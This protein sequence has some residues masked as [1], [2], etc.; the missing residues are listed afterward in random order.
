MAVAIAVLFLNKL[1]GSLLRNFG[2]ESEFVIEILEWLRRALR[3]SERYANQNYI[4]YIFHN[5]KAR[6]SII[7]MLTIKDSG[8]VSLWQRKK[9]GIILKL[10]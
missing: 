2:H 9:L 10:K 6:K 3:A 7:I 1:I 5:F 4:N 8:D